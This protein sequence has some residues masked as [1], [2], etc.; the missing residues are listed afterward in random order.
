MKVLGAS[1]ALACLCLTVVPTTAHSAGD[2]T[3]PTLRTPIKTSFTVGGQIS[4]GNDPDCSDT[5][6][7]GVV[8]VMTTQIFAWRGSDDSGSVRYGVVENPKGEESYDVVTDST[9]TSYD[10]LTTN[11]NQECGGGSW[12]PASW[13]VTATDPAGNATT[14]RVSGGLFQLTQDTNDTDDSFYAIQPVITY[15]GPWG[16]SSCACWSDGS[17]HRTSAVDASARIV[18]RVPA[19]K[20]SHLGLVMVKAPNR[21]SFALYLDGVRT[22]TVNTFAAT[23]KPRSIVWQSSIPA[24]LHRVRIINL[25]TAGHPRIDLDA[26][27]TN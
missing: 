18:M 27:L 8:W 2:T 24:G 22:A 4:V 13:D 1:A 9:Q 6:V 5:H 16:R 14:H 19:G 23:N 7:P 26:V 21:G 3:P 25:A 20:V 17:T 15:T 11:A 12:M 10:P